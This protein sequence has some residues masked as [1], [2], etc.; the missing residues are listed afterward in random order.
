MYSMNKSVEQKGILQK[1]LLESDND[2]S[3][4]KEFK[5]TVSPNDF[6]FTTIC[7]LISNNKIEIPYFQRNFVWDK[8][9][10]SKLIESFVLGF[11][12]PQ[13]YLY[14]Q[15][16]GKF[17]VIDGQQRLL[18]MYFFRQGWFPRNKRRHGLGQLTKDKSL[19]DEN[20]EPSNYEKFQ[21]VLSPFYDGTENP[22][23]GKTYQDLS[24]T[25]KDLLDYR[26]IRT[27]VIETNPSANKDDSMSQAYEIYNRLNTGGT[28][29]KPQEIRTSLF[30]GTFYNE[31]NELNNEIIWRKIVGEHS[32]FKHMEDVEYLLRIIALAEGLEF[33]KPPMNKFL[34]TFSL[35]AL[36]PSQQDKIVGW[37]D[38]F[39]TF[40]NSLEDPSGIFVNENKKFS[41]VLL[42]SVYANFIHHRSQEISKRLVHSLRDNDEFKASMHENTTSRASILKRL[43]L[44]KDI[45][46][47]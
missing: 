10:S 18:S 32:K 1:G 14:R 44:A 17:S 15:T 47:K 43:N 28:N 40:L 8:K 39:K 5:A 45:V 33:Y 13:I 20:F 21:L 7:D 24:E 46:F 30:H 4:V 6:N 16:N 36:K 38:C 37:T 35:Y 9:Q 42:E 2:I 11:P 34:N 22:L 25:E 27:M 23:N 41:L 29:L 12:V 31:L 26:A 3:L 19:S